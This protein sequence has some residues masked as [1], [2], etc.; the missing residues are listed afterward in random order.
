MTEKSNEQE[1]MDY[2]YGSL[3]KEEKLKF[4][5]NLE[6]HPELQLELEELMQ[7]KNILGQVDDEEVIAPDFKEFSIEKPKRRKMPSAVWAISSIAASL[8]LL[9]TLGY[10]TNF[11]MQISRDGFQLGFGNLSN[12]TPIEEPNVYLAKEEIDALLDAKLLAARIDWENDLGRA[13]NTFQQQFAAHKV[14]Q[15]EQISYLAKQD[16]SLSDEQVLNFV[17]QMKDDN[18]QQIAN[19]FNASFQEQDKYVQQ[20]L[21]EF[22]KYLNEQ[23]QED[24]KIIQANFMELRSNTDERQ[25]ET[26]KIL[27]SI[28]T[29]VNNQNSA[30]R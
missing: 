9:M 23:R 7:T 17:D 2:I 8:L 4:E 18:K 14:A 28:I 29:T 26:E 19:F 13:E 6:Q 21:S 3:T 25:Y 27:T 10:F 1:F 24:L 15:K 11:G 30:G 16:K 20:V 12:P 22:A 5:K